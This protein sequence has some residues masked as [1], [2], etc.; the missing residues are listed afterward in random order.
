MML[1]PSS[2]CIAWALG[3]SLALWTSATTAGQTTTFNGVEVPG[4]V[5]KHSPASTGV[6]LGSP[7]IVVLPNDELLASFEYF[8][9]NSPTP[10][11]T[12]VYRST[13]G[14]ETWVLRS[15]LFDMAWGGMFVHNDDVYFV[16][17]NHP[18]E[19]LVIRKS[20]NN[21]ATWT[22]ATDTSDGILRQESGALGYHTAP[23]PVVV[24]EGR[25]W[26][27]YEDNAAPGIGVWPSK[28]RSGLMSAPVDADLLDSSN[29]T[30]TNL[31]ESDEDWLPY[32]PS[33]PYLGGYFT[34][35]LEGNA[36]VGPDGKVVNVMRVDVEPGRPEYAAITRAQ[37]AS[38]LTFDHTQD[39]VPMPGGS[40]KFSIR[41]NE[42][43]G[44]YWA[45]G[46]IVNEDNYDFDERPATIRNTLAVL[47][48]T[49]LTDW[50]VED[51]V[52]QDLSDPE[53]I[54]FQYVDWQFDGRDIVAL[55]RTAFPDGLGGAANFHDANFITFHRFKNVLPALAIEGDLDGDGFVGIDDL[56]I[57]LGNWNQNVPPATPLADPSGDGFVGIDDLNVVLGNWNAGAPPTASTNIPE[58]AS[59]AL[60]LLM[61]GAK[62]LPRCKPLR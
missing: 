26:R 34:G 23:V 19:N 54:A 49:D 44:T 51:I 25:I 14:G 52:L 55:S 2:R 28:Y 21:G 18:L 15:I 42:D 4:T 50:V 39:I 17:V 29:W 24:A 8:G 5:L 22:T 20:T 59:L 10:K 16:G 3:V 47:Q 56:N 48:S 7:S 58:P 11:R 1:R 32:A 6:Y 13:N 9:S 33:A 12:D 45:L 61:A 37:D 30:F 35:W 27:A 38:T 62:M 57:V 43:T 60:I 53:N 31:I 36:V 41:Y 40:K 46:N